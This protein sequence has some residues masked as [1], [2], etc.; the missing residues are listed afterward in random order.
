M[1]ETRIRGYHAHVYFD[2]GSLAQA[3]ALCAAAAERFALKM[4]RMHEKKVGPHP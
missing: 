2:A 1:S 4:G 3:R